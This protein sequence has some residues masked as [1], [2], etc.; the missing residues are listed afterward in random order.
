MRRL[1]VVLVLAVFLAACGDSPG[2]QQ[3]NDVITDAMSSALT[4][5]DDVVDAEIVY[6]NNLDASASAA[7]KV[8]VAE[9]ADP[10][11]VADEVVR[12]LWTSTLTPLNGVSVSVWDVT[13]N[14]R[15][16]VRIMSFKDAATRSDLEAELGPRPV[17]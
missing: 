2:E 10:R 1:I 6:Q 4:A 12:L 13:D 11:P 16:D 8:T 9:G 14:K 17:T 5:R 7:V 15:S 3:H